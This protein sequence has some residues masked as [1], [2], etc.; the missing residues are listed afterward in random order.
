MPNRPL[1]VTRRPV[2]RFRFNG[3]AARTDMPECWDRQHRPGCLCSNGL[4]WS[5]RN[6]VN[7]RPPAPVRLSWKTAAEC[8]YLLCPTCDTRCS[9]ASSDATGGPAPRRSLTGHFAGQALRTRAPCTPLGGQARERAMGPPGDDRPS[10]ARHVPEAAS[11][12]RGDSLL[13]SP[14]R[15]A[16][17]GRMAPAPHRPAASGASR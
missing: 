7:K 12:T 8:V 3:F 2:A 11:R 13:A 15:G 9:T 10:T 5:P 4:E 1:K 14:A 16:G 6:A 17:L